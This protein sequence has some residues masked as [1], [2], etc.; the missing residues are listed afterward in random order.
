MTE[1]L[2]DKVKGELLSR[3]PLGR[4]GDPTDVADVVSFLASEEARYVTGQVINVDGGM[5][6]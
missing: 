3:I 2:G 6:M 4:L 5:V 1:G